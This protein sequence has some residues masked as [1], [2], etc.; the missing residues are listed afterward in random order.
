MPDTLAPYA[1]AI[2]ALLTPVVVALLAWLAD[3][4]GVEGV[5]DPTAVG[6]AVTALVTGLLVY[7][8]RNRAREP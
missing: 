1:K 8:V 4:A 7:L 5:P 6:T 3:R 2:A